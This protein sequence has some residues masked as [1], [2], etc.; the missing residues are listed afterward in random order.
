[1][2]ISNDVRVD[3]RQD[4]VAVVTLNRPHVRNAI[5]SAT[6]VALE[7]VLVALSDDPECGCVVLAASGEAFCA[8]FDTHEMA[9]SS[10]D[11]LARL[12]E[13]RPG[14]IVRIIQLPIPIVAAINGPA[15]GAGC[16]LAVA[17]DLRI[18]SE[19]ASFTFGAA[20]FGGVMFTAL[21]PLLVGR[22][23]ASDYLMTARTVP[24]EDAFHT[25]LLNRL[26][27]GD[28]LLTAA[29]DTAAMIA[30]NS[31]ASVR[32]IKELLRASDGLDQ[33]S[34]YELEVRAETE[35]IGTQH[36]RELFR[37]FLG[38]SREDV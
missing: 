8:G 32:K 25:G 12:R 2:T 36:S 4:R 33:Q 26:V 11:E 6:Q 18:G 3:R 34:R 16:L 23:T 15:H 10:D 38:R 17:S 22:A 13:E 7:Q 5:D 20:S 9:N 30:S 24:A 31:P 21:L 1:M 28:T 29:V 14:W 37:S 19:R 35:L 27:P